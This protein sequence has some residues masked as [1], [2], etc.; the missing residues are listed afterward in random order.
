[1]ACEPAAQAARVGFEP[2]HGLSVRV[3]VCVVGWE[4]GHSGGSCSAPRGRAQPLLCTWPLPGRGRHDWTLLVKQALTED[5]LV[6]NAMKIWWLS[7]PSE[8]P[9][10]L[11]YCFQTL[12]DRFTSDGAVEWSLLPGLDP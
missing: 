1:M 5:P 10:Y 6:R 4:P 7:V 9:T 3:C 11:G 8:A 2:S 12:L